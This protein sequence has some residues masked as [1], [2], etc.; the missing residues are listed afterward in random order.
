MAVTESE[1]VVTPCSATPADEMKSLRRVQRELLQLASSAPTKQDL[2]R[3]LAQLL[4][5][6]SRPVATFYFERNAQ[7]EL[8]EATRLHPAETDPDADRSAKWLASACQAACRTGE[9]DVRRQTVPPR[10]YVA[11]PIPQRGRDPDALGVVFN[12]CDS[13]PHLMMLIQMVVSHIV[14]WNVIASTR[15]HEADARDSDALLELLERVINAGDLRHACYTLADEVRSHLSCRRVMVGVR[16]DGK[17]RCRVAAISGVAQFEG[18]SEAAQTI[19]AAMEEAVLRGEVTAWPP[20]DDAHRH[21]ALAHKNLCV[22][23]ESSAVVSVPLCNGAGAAIGVLVALDDSAASLAANGRFLRAAA[24][25]LATS[26]DAAQRLEGGRMTRWIRGADRTW[27]TWRGKAA[28]AAAAGIL[29]ALLIPWSSQVHCDCRIEPVTRRF[30][31]AP[32]EATLEKSF[33]KP[34]DIVREGDVLARLDGREI[35]WQRA[36]VVADQNQAR[37]K[38]DVAQAT[39]NYADQQIAQLEMERLELE[40]RLLDHRAENLEIRSPVD[41]VI[42]S[43]DLER[44]EGAPLKVGQTLFEV[45]P[46][47]KM[48][49]EIAVPDEEISR[50][51]AGQPVDV[52]LDA[53]PGETWRAVVTV[54]QPRAEIRD[55]KNVFIAEAELGNADGRLRPG[56]KGRTKVAADRRSLGWILFHKPWEYATKKLIW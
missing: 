48:I 16:R 27:R 29:A 38:R 41:G 52:R 46:L 12:V 10:I 42:A 17:G 33:A 43:G 8:A 15:D 28:V 3:G 30:V 50:V 36:G 6:Y 54:V 40:L 14:L 32:F 34:G 35:R 31:A 23:E 4:Y 18:R 51:A 39:H 5:R 25:L 37:K 9:L 24:P 20:L 47:E 22:R 49:V 45:G 7:G 11:A 53:Y 19:E 1:A 26:L 13:T 55:Q 21:A 44:A 2:L 56:M